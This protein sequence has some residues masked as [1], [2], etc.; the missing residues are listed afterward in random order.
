MPVAIWATGKRRDGGWRG[1]RPPQRR[2]E[3]VI[4]TEEDQYLPG[5]SAVLGSAVYLENLTFMKG[6][7]YIRYDRSI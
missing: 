3:R 1:Y 7:G 2:E 6:V 4:G 5:I